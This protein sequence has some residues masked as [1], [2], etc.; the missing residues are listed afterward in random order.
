MPAAKLGVRVTDPGT[1]RVNMHGV[2]G[3]KE[4]GEAHLD[5]NSRMFS[6]IGHPL[7]RVKLNGKS[8][9]ALLDT[10]ASTSLV[11]YWGAKRMK[12]NPVGPPL[13]RMP[14]ASLGG[15]TEQILGVA[16][17]LAMDDI[18][19]ERV[20]F[21]VLN[22]AR[23]TAAY[24]WLQGYRVETIIGNNI[25]SALS[26]VS[27]DIANERVTMDARRRYVPSSKRL[28]GDTPLISR[29]GVPVV[30]ASVDQKPMHVAIDSGGMFGLWI[31]RP[32]ANDAGMP[33]VESSKDVELGHGVAG[34]ILQKPGQPRTLNFVGFDIP[35]VPT[36]FSLVQLGANEP[37]YA[38]LGTEVMKRYVVTIDYLAR[39]VYFERPE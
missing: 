3:V 21:G 9:I 29:F 26:Y 18:T 8:T 6:D 36:S 14:V 23:G 25:L 32:V 37:P 27:F 33:E 35:D 7:I 12:L 5:L 15:G 10:G 39:K 24:R 11:D 31:P 16:K 17:S 28:L 1:P 38:L 4:A 30:L 34:G 2:L 13:V 20:P 22:D 19:L